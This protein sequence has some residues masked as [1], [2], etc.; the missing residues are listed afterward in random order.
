MISDR[1]RTLACVLIL[2]CA[3]PGA[4]QDA[5]DTPAD[6]IF[7]SAVALVRQGRYEEAR[8]S[9]TRLLRL[10]PHRRTT[11]AAVMEAKC[12]L[13]LGDDVGAARSMREFVKRY[14]RSA[15]LPDAEYMLGIALA[16]L[17]RTDDA[18]AALRSAWRRLP[19][20][21]GGRLGRNIP[22]ALEIILR[23]QVSPPALARLA[24]GGAPGERALMLIVLA[25]K[26]AAGGNVVAAG[27]VADSLDRLVPAHPY[28]ERVA[29]V[30]ATAARRSS[31]K[32][33]VLVPLMRSAEPSAAKEI[34]NDV[35]NGMLL[36]QE[37]HA[38]SPERRVSVEFV[39]K[40]TDR[41]PIRA[42]VFALELAGDPDVVAILGP[43]FSQ[44]T[45]RAAAAVAQRGIPL[46]TPTANANGI[47]ALGPAVF[48]ANPDYDHRGRAMA[49]Y[50]VLEAGM[51]ALAVLAPADAHGRAM[52]E[53]FVAEAARLGAPV[54]AAEWYARD[55]TD[56][57]DPLGRIRAAVRASGAEPL[58]NFAGRVRP[59]D[60]ARLVQAGVPPA[61][62]DSLMERSATVRASALLGPRARR[63]IDSLQLQGMAVQPPL[64]GGDS[65]AV[66]LDGIYLP[67]GAAEEIGVV[68]SQLAYHNIRARILGSGEWH[69]LDELDANRRYCTGVTFESDS[70]VREEDPG[71]QDFRSRFEA[72]FGAPPGRNALYGYDTARM[73]LG[74]INAGA[75]TRPALAAALARVRDYPGYHSRVTLLH[76]RVNSWLS[77]LRYEGDGVRHLLDVDAGGARGGE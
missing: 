56:L 26:E 62:L 32:V 69:A 3:A 29:V 23:A 76:R 41:N 39:V 58:L 21:G 44:T 66:V 57:G 67:I 1:L 75:S 51:S 20:G 4:A 18:V 14:P 45:Q 11:A 9:F 70:H 49:R 27:A 74:L 53:A 35:Y 16:R 17:S 52:G 40:D 22:S 55:A 15:Y 46:V 30:R 47:A 33:G 73:V 10:P 2:C 6:R 5:G 7:S 34:G 37:E 68:S 60:R 24:A 72:R 71:Y 65:A 50:A 36:A 48:Q 77:I 61:T 38:S 13:E 8:E 28:A 12:A 42:E 63:I 25:E 54:L 59:G 31:V 19:P 43:V 64:P